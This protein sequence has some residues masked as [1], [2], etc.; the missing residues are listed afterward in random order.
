[1][2]EPCHRLVAL[3]WLQPGALEKSPAWGQQVLGRPGGAVSSRGTAGVAEVALKVTSHSHALIPEHAAPEPSGARAPCV[4]GLGFLHH[5]QTAS[6]CQ[7][8]A[9]LVFSLWSRAGK[10]KAVGYA[11]F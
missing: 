7:E 10:S 9:M 5:L 2:A 4:P 6:W 8:I 1:M 3:A 11:E